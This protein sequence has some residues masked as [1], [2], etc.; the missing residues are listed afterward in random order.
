[1][2]ALPSSKGWEE[3]EKHGKTGMAGAPPWR[4]TSRLMADVLG[5]LEAACGWF[6]DER[7]NE[8]DGL[9]SKLNLLPPKIGLDNGV[10][11]PGY[12]CSSGAGTS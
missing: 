6:G 1:M 2:K 8:I 12:L 5:G 11:F 9:L 4:A 10:H 7:K 3:L